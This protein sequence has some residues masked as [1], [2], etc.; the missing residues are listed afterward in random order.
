MHACSIF[1]ISKNNLG[2]IIFFPSHFDIIIDI[3][4]LNWKVNLSFY[5]KEKIIRFF[6]INDAIVPMAQPSFCL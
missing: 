2:L 1:Y 4:S 3:I 5:E 6:H